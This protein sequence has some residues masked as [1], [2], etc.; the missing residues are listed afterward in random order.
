MA[1]YYDE[2][3]DYI[4][5][6]GDIVAFTAQYGGEDRVLV[7]RSRDPI[8]STIRGFWLADP[9]DLGFFSSGGTRSPSVRTSRSF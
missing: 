3:A 2:A 9:C 1:F 7:V 4:G 8:F 6:T 5:L